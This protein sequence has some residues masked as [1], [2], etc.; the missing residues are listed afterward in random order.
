MAKKTTRKKAGRKA[1]GTFAKGNG[2]GPGGKRAG[3]GPT[4][5]SAKQAASSFFAG[6]IDEARAALEAALKAEITLWVEVKGE[7][8]DQVKE[9]ITVPDHNTRFKAATTVFQYTFG[10]PIE[11][12]EVDEAGASVL[13]K[14]SREKA[15]MVARAGRRIDDE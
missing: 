12:V 8:E 2:G 9:P 11:R 7:G 14:L 15:L 10:K 3:A 1:D 5:A 4:P 6:Y 13:D